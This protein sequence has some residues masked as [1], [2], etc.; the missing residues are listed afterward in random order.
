MTGAP[1]TRE[2]TPYLMDLESTNGTKLNGDKIVKYYMYLNDK[3]LFNWYIY[4]NLLD[5]LN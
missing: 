2:I 3:K 1:S 4:R 5:I